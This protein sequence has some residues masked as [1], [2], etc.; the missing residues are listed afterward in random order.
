M[1]LIAV[2]VGRTTLL[3]PLEEITPLE[4]IMGGKLTAALVARY[5][6]KLFPSENMPREELNK[7][8][9]K[10][11]NGQFVYM[12]KPVP[13]A[14]LAVFSDGIVANSTST[15][16]AS[17]FISDLLEYVRSQFGFREFT[18][19]PRQILASQLIVEFDR[20]L[21]RLIPGFAKIQELLAKE[22]GE[23]YDAPMPMDF[24]RIDFQLD[25]EKSHLEY[26]VPRFTIERRAGVSFSQERYYCGALMHTKSHLAIL[27]SIEKM[28]L[29]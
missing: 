4:P 18:S 8:G 2:D 5:G 9:A 15:E 14:E 10:F 21:A 25:K 7:N 3:F 6:F 20:P 19:K 22:T 17:A 13:I 12:D 24:F 28:L 26:A 11:E 27:E 16:A 29:T 1:R 23:V